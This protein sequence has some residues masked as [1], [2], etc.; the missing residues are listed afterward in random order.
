M[1]QGSGHKCC[2]AEEEGE[3]RPLE[4]GA[5]R[6]TLKIQVGNTEREKTG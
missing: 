2:R 1:K 3:T 5:A 4:V 6:Y